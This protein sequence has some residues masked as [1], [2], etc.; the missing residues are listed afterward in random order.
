MLIISKSTGEYI[1]I[2][3][4][5]TEIATKL[6]ICMADNVAW[7]LVDPGL[8]RTELGQVLDIRW[9][10]LKGSRNAYPVSPYR[11]RNGYYIS[12]AGPV[13][14]IINSKEL[15]RYSDGSQITGY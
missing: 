2:Y 12:L 8:V 15:R 6:A 5:W 11:C 9:L 1:R 7:A 3:M 4:L 13:A 10:G 14:L